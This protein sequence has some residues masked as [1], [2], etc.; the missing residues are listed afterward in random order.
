MIIVETLLCDSAASTGS[1]KPIR[2]TSVFTLSTPITHPVGNVQ[3]IA[4]KPKNI[5]Q[6]D[7]L[8]ESRKL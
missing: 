3:C 1:K 4:I 7:M 5:T 2:S 6:K 8:I